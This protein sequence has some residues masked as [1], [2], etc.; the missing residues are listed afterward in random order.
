MVPQVGCVVLG[1][2]AC[3]DLSRLPCLGTRETAPFGSLTPNLPVP[4][5]LFICRN[6]L[7][8]PSCS[9]FFGLT[10]NLQLFQL[11]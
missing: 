9:N 2:A 7:M 11:C 8:W 3:P 10:L 6:R 4:T 1:T 5:F